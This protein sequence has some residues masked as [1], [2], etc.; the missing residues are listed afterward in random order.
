[1]YTA[2]EKKVEGEIRL[3][4]YVALC[5]IAQLRDSRAR[6]SKAHTHTHSRRFKSSQ[7]ETEKAR[8][9]LIIIHY[10]MIMNIRRC[11]AFV[12]V[13]MYFRVD[14]LFRALERIR[15]PEMV[16][17]HSSLGP[18]YNHLAEKL[19]LKIIKKPISIY[20]TFFTIYTTSY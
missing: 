3:I 15:G 18:V 2:A 17:P 14:F 16:C 6:E 8:A 13:C 5:G 11:S 19:P 7:L 4:H 9:P 10:T 1:M 12:C 20:K